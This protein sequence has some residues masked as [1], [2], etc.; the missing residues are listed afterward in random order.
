MI[1]KGLR[2][3]LTQ[4]TPPAEVEA[5]ASIQKYIF[6]VTYGRSGSTLLQSMLGQLENTHLA[7]ENLGVPFDLAKAYCSAVD[8]KKQFS[9][10]GWEPSS[11]W[12]GIQRSDP[13]LLGAHCAQIVYDNYIRPPEGTRIAGFKEVRW[14]S[15]GF[16]LQPTIRFLETFFQ[17]CYFIVNIRDPEATSR[18]GWWAK[19]PKEETIAMLTGY[20]EELIAFASRNN[21][22]HLV[23]YDE[24]SVEPSILE[25][26]F[27]F[28]GEPYDSH[29]VE[30]VMA[31]RLTHTGVKGKK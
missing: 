28:L 24:Y 21:N 8:A 10:L 11:S 17:P 14:V 5:M 12:Y 6:V 29:F 20:R 19:M 18:S 13:D 16:S 27:G 7:G 1:R 9:N 22:A 4:I 26:M 2:K 23:N 15:D 25:D 31:K 3:V 30:S